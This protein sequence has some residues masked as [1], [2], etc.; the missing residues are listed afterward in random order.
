M[1]DNRLIRVQSCADC[2]ESI[3]LRRHC[4]V[5]GTP[6]ARKICVILGEWWA[7]IMFVFIWRRSLFCCCILLCYSRHTYLYCYS[8]MW[9]PDWFR[10]RSGREV[11]GSCW[12]NAY[13]IDAPVIG[14]TWI[15]NCAAW[16]SVVCHMQYVVRCETAYEFVVLHYEIFSKKIIKAWSR[17]CWLNCASWKVLLSF[18]VLLDRVVVIKLN[19]FSTLINVFTESRISQ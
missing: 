17:E 5:S 4:S 6:L 3:W 10:M 19:S 11:L 14:P 16:R 8:R 15:R 7:V 13:R 18:A 9:H 2:V 1:L 12:R